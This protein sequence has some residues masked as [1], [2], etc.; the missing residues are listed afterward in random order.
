MGDALINARGFENAE[1][2]AR[3]S[4]DDPGST[5]SRI[6]VNDPPQGLRLLQLTSL[7]QPF[8]TVE[9]LKIGPDGKAVDG[10]LEE[11]PYAGARFVY[12]ARF[13]DGS[14]RRHIREL[15]VNL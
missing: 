10:A 3:Y 4:H 15:E 9:C 6:L 7:A 5:H 13:S 12:E 14:P 8:D 11:V 2:L 1:S